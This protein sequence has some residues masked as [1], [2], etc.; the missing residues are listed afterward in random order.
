M[1]KITTST[2]SP[3]P[4]FVFCVCLFLHQS[5]KGLTVCCDNKAILIVLQAVS[6]ELS[7]DFYVYMYTIQRA[8]ITRSI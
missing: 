4:Q 2:V 6:L 1:N 3:N 5:L 8:P 7:C